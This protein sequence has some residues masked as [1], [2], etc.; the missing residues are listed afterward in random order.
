ML[1]IKDNVELDELRKYGLEKRESYDREHFKEIELD[2]EDFVGWVEIIGFQ[3]WRE[4]YYSQSFEL[5]ELYDL[6]QA[7]LVE[8]IEE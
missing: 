4:T 6:I 1:K 2:G 3:I 8:K 5:E 7:G